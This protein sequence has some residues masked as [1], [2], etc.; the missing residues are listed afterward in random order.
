MISSIFG[1]TSPINF[2]I[3]TVFVFLFMIIT[4]AF[5][6]DVSFGLG[7]V[8]K[9]VLSLIIIFF[10]LFLIDFIDKKNHLSD[11]NSYISLFFVLIL[12]LF[13]KIFHETNML[14]SNFFVLLA[15]RRVISMRSNRDMEIKI[16][17]ASL[18]IF[19]AA[20]FYSW[21]IFFIVLVFLALFLY[22]KN[23]YRN[24]LIPFVTLFVVTL[25]AF[26]YFFLSDNM[27]GF[28]LMLNFSPQFIIEKYVDIKY[29]VPLVFMCIMG[30]WGLLFFFLK[31]KS[32]SFK[33][34]VPGLLVFSTLVIAILVAVVSE[35][36]NTSELIY[37]AF[38]IAVMMAK[39]VEWIKKEWLKEA[40][41]WMF[42]L[43]PLA[44]LFL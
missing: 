27:E 29:I 11:R 10:T 8:V 22:K 32:K 9:A 7:L 15:F 2:L 5:H 26:T 44:V 40:L 4:Y 30:L 38:P 28:L 34:R 20:F 17:D 3:L 25:L 42:V 16:F 33:A 39:Y 24:L 35:S 37:V 1:R 6:L 43:V 12:C 13:P 36:A 31:K 41:I 23:D 18:W 19:V 14:I 21:A